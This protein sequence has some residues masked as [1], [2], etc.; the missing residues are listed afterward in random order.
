MKF[1]QKWNKLSYFHWK[2]NQRIVHQINLR[3]QRV[4]VE[5]YQSREMSLCE[6]YLNIFLHIFG[7]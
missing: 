7:I 3:S 4:Q 1:L 6:V 5:S 2:F